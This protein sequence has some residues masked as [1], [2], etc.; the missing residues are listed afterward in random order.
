MVVIKFRLIVL[1]IFILLL[2]KIIKV[3][4]VQVMYTPIFHQ[5][6]SV[7]LLLY[8]FYLRFL[9]LYHLVNHIN[10]TPTLHYLLLH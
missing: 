8:F 4:R 9:P 3:R 6:I 7:Q 5:A 1:I 2:L 10:V